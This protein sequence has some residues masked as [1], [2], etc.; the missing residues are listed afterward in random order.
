MNA[1]VQNT[2]I[3]TLRAENIQLRREV[4]LLRA[5]RE[6]AFKDPLTAL[7]NRRA[8]DERLAQ[9]AMRAERHPSGA[10]S[11]LTV[12]LNE[13]KAI[14]DTH[15]HASG[16]STLQW[17][18]DFLERAVREMDVVFRT[19]GDEFTIL[20]PETGPAERQKVRVRLEERLQAE[21]GRAEFPVGLSL[22]GATWGEDGTEIMAI[23][24]AADDAMYA[25]K[26]IKKEL[27]MAAGEIR[28]GVRISF[29]AD[30]RSP[31]PR[32]H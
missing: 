14:N 24:D 7:S 4:E 17:V 18:A 9:E 25:D 6:L 27:R 13:F 29:L 16:D 32:H 28:D 2:L 21:I 30:R 20:L 19:G 1:I 3:D 23:L 5:Y 22:G 15:G 10:F 31:G 11:V 8:L 12:D 26:R